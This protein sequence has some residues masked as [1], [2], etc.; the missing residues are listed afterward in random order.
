[1]SAEERLG[2]CLVRTGA[3]RGGLQA[4]VGG[5]NWG[6]ARRRKE[7]GGTLGEKEVMDVTAL[8]L[9]GI[10]KESGG[11]GGIMARRLDH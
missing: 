5:N 9:E 6:N 8:D 3:Y 2:R 10:W 1:M 11:K 4:R 7:I